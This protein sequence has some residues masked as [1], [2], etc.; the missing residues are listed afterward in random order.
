MNLRQ[1]SEEMADGALKNYANWIECENIVTKT[2]GNG[3]V[4]HTSVQPRDMWMK[5]VDDQECMDHSV[6]TDF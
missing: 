3:E 1:S 2:H 6:K 4:T 5:Q